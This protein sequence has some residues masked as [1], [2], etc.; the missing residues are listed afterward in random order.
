[1]GPGQKTKDKTYC[2]KFP[3][4]SVTVDCVIFGWDSDG[5]H[6]LLIERGTEPL[7]GQWALPG[8]FIHAGEED[9]EEAARRELV[10]ETGIRSAYLE[11]LGTYGHPDRDPREEHVITVAY[12]ALVKRIDHRPRGGTDARLADWMLIEEAQRTGLAFDHDKILADAITRLYGK[13]RY[14][15]LGF[16]MLPNK[17]PLRDVQRLYETAIGHEVD[18]RN[19]RK[20][21]LEMGLL[22]DTGETESDV[23]HR[24]ARLY[25]FNNA[26]Y[27][28][29]SRQ[30]WKFDI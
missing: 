1:M 13:L 5:L 24:A 4:V 30:G 28:K 29:R 25:R 2:Y 26:E 8:G 6:V 19:F 9:L 21:L 20:K 27:E 11:Q 16:K 7:E 17:F 23:R 22:E 15:P 3:M 12:V 18:K 14:D 10:E